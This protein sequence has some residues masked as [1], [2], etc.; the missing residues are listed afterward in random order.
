M[1]YEATR[2][3]WQAVTGHHGLAATRRIVLLALAECHNGETGRCDPSLERLIQMTG[4]KRHTIP[5]SIRDLE[6]AGLVVVSRGLGQRSSY[7]LQTSAEN[8]TSAHLGTSA[9]NG[10]TTSAENGTQTRNRT[11]N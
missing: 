10:T 8:G 11:R 3:A 6:S 1:S 9:E 2:W 7:Q 5:T 4:L